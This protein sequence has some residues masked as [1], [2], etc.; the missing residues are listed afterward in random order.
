M[1]LIIVI[2]EVVHERALRTWLN[3]KWFEQPW[4]VFDC[5]HNQKWNDVG[6]IC[7]RK[8]K[9][10]FFSF[11]FLA[12]P[13]KF[14]RIAD[15]TLEPRLEMEMNGCNVDDKR[16]LWC[17]KTFVNRLLIFS[18]IREFANDYIWR[19]KK[20]IR[21]NI[22]NCIRNLIWFII[23]FF[24]FCLSRLRNLRNALCRFT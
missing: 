8:K 18:G 24:G 10:I 16:L 13:R 7:G 19:N 12:L 22:G 5:L 20:K 1:I 4:F 15:E 2:R 17:N 14:S 11:L 23:S 21:W 6:Y 9:K 3:Q